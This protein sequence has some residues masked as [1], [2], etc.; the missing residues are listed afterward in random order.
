MYK[1][2]NL[3]NYIYIPEIRVNLIL[4]TA[5]DNFNINVLFK[6]E[7]AIISKNNKL[8]ILYKE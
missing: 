4:I 3:N 5:L 7:R 6:L 2:L 1:I 8:I